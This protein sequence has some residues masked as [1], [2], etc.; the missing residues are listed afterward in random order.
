MNE[1]STS[2]SGDQV[3]WANFTTPLLSPTGSA[4]VWL[5]KSRAFICRKEAD[6]KGYCMTRNEQ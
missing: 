5:N 2:P 3:V 6:T 1:R 4:L